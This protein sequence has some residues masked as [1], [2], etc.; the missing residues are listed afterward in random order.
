LYDFGVYRSYKFDIPIIAIGNLSTGGTGKTPHIEY[1]IRLLQAKWNIATLSRGY[2]R[3]TK[4]F[5]IATETTK[6]TEVGDEPLQFKKKFKNIVV[7]VENK[8]VLGV[9]KLRHLYPNINLILLDDAF[10]HRAIH[11][12]LS[13]LLTEYNKPFSNDYVLPTGN[14]REFAIGYKRANIIVVTKTPSNLTEADKTKMIQ[15]IKPLAHQKVYFSYI[16]YNNL[17]PLK[18]NLS[19]QTF[20]IKYYLENNYTITLFTGIANAYLLENYLKEQTN[21]IH[22]FQYSDHHEYSISELQTLK[23]FFTQL[24]IANKIIITT[25]KDA[26]R[27]TAPAFKELLSTLPLFYI[28]IEIQFHKQDKAHFEKDISTYLNTTK[29]TL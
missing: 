22:A 6:A 13:I 7:A 29:N 4:K 19:T 3:A 17:I 23:D 9:Q 26:M 21:N 14:L 8:R 25:E 5:T 24:P 20:P 10:Q 16:V 15:Q 12:G 1:L 18:N 2:G 11:L 28:P 27:L